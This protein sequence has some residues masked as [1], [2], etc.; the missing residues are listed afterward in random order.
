MKQS[1]L[2]KVCVLFFIFIV[3][4]SILSANREEPKQGQEEES[5]LN[6]PTS[7]VSD[8]PMEEDI[9]ILMGMENCEE[10]DEE[11]LRRRMMTDAHLD[12][13]YTQQHKN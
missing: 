8:T 11:C 9:N 1:F 3:F 10:A 12:Y 7:Q 2:L 5:T 13:I 6:L 4:S